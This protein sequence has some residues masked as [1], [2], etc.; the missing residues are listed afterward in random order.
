MPRFVTDKDKP[1]KAIILSDRIAANVQTRQGSTTTSTLLRV[2]DSTFHPPGAQA[3]NPRPPGM[4]RTRTI[5]YA[6]YDPL[7]P[8]WVT[9]TQRRSP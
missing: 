6:M 5:D 4:H 9:P 7:P 8:K 2:T 3:Q 1:G